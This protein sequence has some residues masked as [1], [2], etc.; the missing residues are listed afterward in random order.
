MANIFQ[1]VGGLLGLNSTPS[2]QD[3]INAGWTNYTPTSPNVTAAN[4]ST[5]AP[6]MTAQQQELGQLQQQAQGLGG[7]TQA[8]ATL[9]SGLG[10]NLAAQ[11]AEMAG[12]RGNNQNFGLANANLSNTSAAANAT[13]A[14]NAAKLRA[15]EQANAQGMEA[16][17]AN[18]GAAQGIG[19]GEYNANLAN[20][21]WQFTNNLMANQAGAQNADIA[22]ITGANNNFN[23]QQAS[24]ALQGLLS[25]ASGASAMGGS[26]G[27]GGGMGGMG[28]LS[29][30]MGSGGGAGAG[31][32]AAAAQDGSVVS[33]DNDFSPG[34]FSNEGDPNPGSTTPAVS[35]Q[36][37]STSTSQSSSSPSTTP[38]VV[39]SQSP[40]WSKLLKMVSNKGPSTSTTQDQSS[41]KSY[42]GVGLGEGEF[43]TGA[44]S[45]IAAGVPEG[46]G[47]TGVGIGTGVAAGGVGAAGTAGAPVAGGAGVGAGAIG[48]LPL[49]LSPIG[50]AKGGVEK[51]PVKKLVGEAGEE[52]IVPTPENKNPIPTAVTR[53][54]AF[55]T[56]GQHGGQAVIP[57]KPDGTVDEKRAKNPAVR[58]LLL[59]HPEYKQPVKA[60]LEHSKLVGGKDIGSLVKA[61]AQAGSQLERQVAALEKALKQQASKKSKRK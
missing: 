58:N 3:Q 25:T 16:N 45:G 28:G 55:M 41:T 21:Q 7:P 33:G 49:L 18:T 13:T 48:A 22:S 17:L 53:G 24:A 31:A 52:A 60:G 30:L 51:G 8:Q 6:F 29:S 46:V 12:A 50:L 20:N 44:S 38:A 57:V 37:P 4:T 10:Q 47:A 19:L 32:A 11:R 35:N 34:D 40:M 56:L 9:Q 43:L 1:D 42:P 23:N 14:A 36:G 59:Q 15:G 54:P 2:A 26:S 61:M 39:G 27:G 5:A